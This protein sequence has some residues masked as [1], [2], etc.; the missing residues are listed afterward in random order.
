MGWVRCLVIPFYWLGESPA[1]FSRASGFSGEMNNKTVELKLNKAALKNAHKV[2]MILEIHRKL[3]SS[4]HELDMIGDEMCKL[5]IQESL[6]PIDQ[7]LSD[8]T[9]SVDA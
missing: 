6:K 9:N 3:T 8:L 4:W 5:S 1:E 2:N 7:L